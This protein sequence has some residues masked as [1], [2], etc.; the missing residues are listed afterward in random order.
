[1]LS[2]VRRLWGGTEIDGSI[3]G[4]G[5]ASGS[6]NPNTRSLVSCQ[7]LSGLFEVVEQRGLDP[8]LLIVDTGRTVDYLRDRRNRVPW[9]DFR[10]V[11]EQL[12]YHYDEDEIV[13]IGRQLVNTAAQR[14]FGLIARRFFSI[15]DFYR[16]VFSQKSGWGKPMF[17]C[18]TSTCIQLATDV[19]E[20]TLELH[21]GFVPSPVFVMITEGNIIGIPEVLGG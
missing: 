3:D 17:P 9:E 18:M 6:D 8:E 13:A 19:F 21:E 15:G 10:L 7:P 2:N 4:G 16:A 12:A 14:P 5:S 20:V 1:M 11:V